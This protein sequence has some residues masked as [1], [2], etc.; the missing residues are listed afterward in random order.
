MGAT[1]AAVLSREDP[2]RFPRVVLT[3]NA[4]E[5]ASATAFSSGFA[6]QRVILSCTTGGCE[7]VYRRSGEILAR[8]RIKVRLDQ[9][10]SSAHG[11]WD[12]VV[13]S[14]RRDWPWLVEG[15]AGWDSYAAPLDEGPSPG[16][17][18]SFDVQP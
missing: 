17:T 16:K 5:P 10:G 9:S 3:A 6:G 13:R 11:I 15:A 7:S 8:R 2:R 18:A 1:Q 14:P 4:Y 12:D